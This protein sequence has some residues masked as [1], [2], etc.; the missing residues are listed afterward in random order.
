MTPRRAR[1]VAAPLLLAGAACAAPPSYDSRRSAVSASERG[2]YASID[3]TLTRR[4]LEPLPP[5]PAGARGGEFQSLTADDGTGLAGLLRDDLQVN[6]RLGGIDLSCVLRKATPLTAIAA[7][8]DSLVV[9]FAPCRANGANAPA[10]LSQATIP[11]CYFQAS[12]DQFASAQVRAE[13]EG[14]LARADALCAAS[15]FPTPPELPPPS[16]PTAE[17]STTA[18]ATTPTIPTSTAAFT[19]CTA[20]RQYEDQPSR[21]RGLDLGSIR[22]DLANSDG[23]RPGAGQRCLISAAIFNAAGHYG[24][25]TWGLEVSGT[26]TV[27]R[28]D[29]VHIAPWS[30]YRLPRDAT[31]EQ[32]RAYWEDQA[33]A[34]LAQ[35]APGEAYDN[36]ES[37]MREMAFPEQQVEATAT[38]SRIP[39]DRFIPQNKWPQGYGEVMIFVQGVDASGHDVGRR[40][41]HQLTISSPLVLHFDVNM[42]TFTHTSPRASRVRFDLRGDGRASDVG[43]ITPAA[44]F[45]VQAPEGR[46]PG[47][48]GDWA[49]V[50]SG[51]QLFGTART[52]ADGRRAPDGFAALAELDADHDGVIDRW[53]AAYAGLRLWHDRNVDGRSDETELTTLAAAGIERLEVRPKGVPD[54]LQARLS[55]GVGDNQ[56]PL[57]ARFFGPER[58]GRI[59]C[60]LFDV[61]FAEEHGA[62]SAGSSAK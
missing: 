17:P 25:A 11:A 20:I 31:L 45:L 40:C 35:K 21:S 3:T 36:H 14:L 16:R 51:K 32:H 5:L 42:Q 15:G 39:F 34:I 30:D 1:R 37:I 52:L 10:A 38:T 4:Q 6:G 18:A 12:R 57:Y 13:I 8:G 7:I 23:C 27:W 28:I 47:L 58:C 9:T 41:I 54:V 33:Q 26:A 48:G 55:R 22:S 19:G 49:D 46:S 29:T 50:T 59:G 44:A 24:G 2:P 53:D 62:I 56:V 60:V 61:F 43:W